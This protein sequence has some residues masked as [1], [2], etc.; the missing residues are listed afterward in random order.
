MAWEMNETDARAWLRNV[1]AV[2][3]QGCT[4]TTTT[5]DDSV[6]DMM[7]T[8]IDSEL[9]WPWI[10]SALDGLLGD[11]PVVPIGA[12]PVF[13]AECEAKGINPLIIIQIVQALIALWQAF[14]PK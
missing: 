14:R 10:W 4:L 12:D 8:A 11:D 3:R 6:A 7:L 1:V 9:L 13:A 5:I 2:I